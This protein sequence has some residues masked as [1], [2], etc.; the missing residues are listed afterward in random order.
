MI[1]IDA[2]LLFCA[3]MKT[4]KS[5]ISKMN[6]FEF[7]PPE[8]NLFYYKKVFKKLKMKKTQQIILPLILKGENLVIS[9]LNLK[10]SRGSNSQRK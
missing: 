10:V 8:L 2:N 4:S 5:K 1:V 7:I 3:F 6:F 9:T